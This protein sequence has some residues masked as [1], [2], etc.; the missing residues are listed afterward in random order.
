MKTKKQKLPFAHLAA[1]HTTVRACDVAPG[2]PFAHLLGHG[3]P[4]LTPTAAAIIDAGERA[5]RSKEGSR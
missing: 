2:T 1:G 5:T 3:D 4:N